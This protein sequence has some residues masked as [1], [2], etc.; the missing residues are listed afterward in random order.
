[1][2]PSLARASKVL[3]LTPQDA[4]A[5]ASRWKKRAKRRQGYFFDRLVTN[6]DAVDFYVTFDS[7]TVGKLKASTWSICQSRFW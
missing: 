6:T 5:A 7:I 4:A 2:I 1:L 3:I